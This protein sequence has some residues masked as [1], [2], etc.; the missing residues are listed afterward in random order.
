MRNTTISRRGPRRQSAGTR[1][2]Q[3]GAAAIFAAVGLVALVIGLVL[4]VNV[5]QLYFAQRDLQ[6]Q[7]SLAAIAGA[8]LASGCSNSGQ[9]QADASANSAL[10]NKVQTAVIANNGSATNMTG[11][12]GFSAVEVGWVNNASGQSV[13][14]DSGTKHT[15]ATDSLRHFVPLANSDSHINAVRVNLSTTVPTLIGGLFPGGTGKLVASATALQS[16]EGSFYL[17][18]SIAS[19]SGGALNGLLGAVLCAPGD[20][21][22]QSSIASLSVGSAY[23]GLANVN[24]SLGQLATAA[25][26]SVQDLSD[27]LALSTQTPVLSKLLNGLASSLGSNISSGTATLLQ[28]LASA[29]TNPSGVPLGSLLNAVDTTAAD[30]PFIDLQSLI[31]ALGES[32]TSGT[33]GQVQPIALPINLDVPG[34]AV[35]RVF[36]DVGAP[37]KF[38]SY[39]PA[40][41]GCD[42]SCA[43][44]A[45]VTLQ[46]RVQAGQALS[47]LLTSINNLIN[48]LLGTLGKLVGLK[49]TVTVASSLNIGADVAVAQATARLDKL[50]CPTVNNVNPV[51]SL[52]A[53][54]SIAAISV[55]T[56]SGTLPASGAAGA[57]PALSTVSS[58]PLA[59]V[60][61]DATGLCVGVKLGNACVGVPLN[62]GATDEV[63]SLGLVN[64]TAGQ[65]SASFQS[66]SNITSFTQQTISGGDPS[67]YYL[68]D[69]AP[70]APNTSSINPQTVGSTVSLA[71]SLPINAQDN[72]PQGLTG[73]LSGLINS[74]LSLVTSAVTPVINLIDAT[75]MPL[76]NGLLSAL[77]VQLGSAT[78]VMDGVVVPSAK[79]VSTAVPTSS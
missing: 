13:T 28:N 40:G 11:I 37:P 17:G 58:L 31:L 22:C 51:A 1:F 57:V 45:E 46:L 79:V 24:V 55:G 54:P 27:P 62:L 76:L 35:V 75:L 4:A 32:S 34:V 41:R 59:E 50:Q 30:V 7:A 15:V 12:N 74:L 64:V 78:V 56:F 9:P 66:L 72:N 8:S 63:L 6:R 36:L 42:T 5:G 29:S 71:V 39:V 70:G 77:G 44:T 38:S 3:R 68:A 10:W 69:G 48:G 52:S 26:I 23:S 19:L 20:T 14:D 33:N 47:G 49:L 43:K 25:G 2:K 67:Y 21:T 16:A 18:T 53:S 73:V 60:N 65:G 61:L